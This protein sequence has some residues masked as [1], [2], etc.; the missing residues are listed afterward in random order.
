MNTG[1]PLNDARLER[2]KTLYKQLNRDTISQSLISDCYADNVLFADPLHRI[3]GIEALTDY[4]VAMYS[5]VEHIDF[6]FTDSWH[7][8]DHSMLRWNM[9]FR[10]P[11]IKGG[12][13]VIV[14]GCT[15]LRWENDKIATHHDFFDAGA[16][17][18]EHLPVLGWAIRKLK[19][20]IL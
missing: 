16:M 19:E 20:R 10:H 14:E 1:L 4:F 2:F 15:E 13:T 3:E 12:N 17:L 6:N 11:R 7:N 8:H 9:S 18:Y 5:N